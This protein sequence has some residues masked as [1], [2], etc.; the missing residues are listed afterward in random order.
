VEVTCPLAKTNHYPCGFAGDD[1]EDCQFRF[2]CSQIQADLDRDLLA[3]LYEAAR[4][5]SYY[6]TAEGEWANE[7]AERM[8]AKETLY[9]LMEQASK[10]GLEY[11]LRGFVI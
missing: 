6:E 4:K 3:R 2:V 11:D 8:K 1:T 9:D 5:V 7:A 10:R